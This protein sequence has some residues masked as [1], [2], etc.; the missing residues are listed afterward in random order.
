MRKTRRRIRRW[1]ASALGLPGHVDIWWTP[2][3][4]VVYVN[5]PKCGCS[6]V[7][8]SLKQAQA[9]RYRRDGRLAFEM[10]A[11]PHAAD[12]CL[13][14]KGIA[15]L[16]RGDT[17]LV[18]SSARN[19]YTRILSAYLD[20]IVSGDICKFHELHGRRP[21]SFEAFLDVLT[22][23]DPST[24]DPH[25]CPQHINLALPDVAYDA[26]F[27]LENLAPLQQALRRAFG[28]FEIETY[29]PHSRSAR[30][31]LQEFYT[32][33][34]AEIVQR[35][36]AG[37]FAR[38]GYSTDLARAS[39]APGEWWTPHGIPHMPRETSLFAAGGLASLMPA[40]RYQRLIEARII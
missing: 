25:F 16:T 3:L 4:P 17:R 29:A 11:D 5:N 28:D 36:Y 39:E 15:D 30:Q 22:E 19:P 7:K 6:T 1:F 40:I 13:K 32:P 35:L 31:K 18:I 24:L 12:D 34:A 21:A 14:R 38:L 27:Y 33:R 10:R 8:N 9:S 2:Q 23:A 26:I 20:K 37:D